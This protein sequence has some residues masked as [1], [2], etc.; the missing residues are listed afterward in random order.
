M[1]AELARLHDRLGVTTVYV[2]HDQ[3]EAMTLGDRVCVML[4][5][6]IQQVDT[7]TRLFQAPA[8]T[9]VAAAIGSPSMNLAVATVDDGR[10]RFGGFC[11]ALPD[12]LRARTAGRA[13]P[14]SIGLRPTDF[15]WRPADFALDDDA[16]VDV[17][18]LPARDA[19]DGRRARRGADGRVSGGRAALRAAGAQQTTASAR[20]PT[21]R[22]CWRSPERSRFT[23]RL[24][25]RQLVRRGQE[26]DLW[27]DAAQLYLFDHETGVAL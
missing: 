24:D 2:T 3:V 4:D 10:V 12:A 26:L 25:M 16:P 21:R 8:N 9:F 11:I 18:R 5:G 6:T 13:A 20:R 15:R 27:F 17:G 23:A 19:R 22:R 1:R 14:S 7:P